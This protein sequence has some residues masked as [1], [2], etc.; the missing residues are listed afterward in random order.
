MKR[1]KTLMWV[2][3]GAVFVLA[4]TVFVVRAVRRD[5]AMHAAL[6]EQQE[7]N[8]ADT[9][10]TSDSV[11]R[12]LVAYFDHPWHRAND[13]MLAHYLLG[14]AH[15][16][17]GEAPQAI[18]DYQTAVECADTTDSDCDFRL[19]RNVYGQMA[20]VFHA[21]NLPEDELK[22]DSAFIRY[23]WM[24][25]DTLQ[26]INGYRAM[27]CPYFLLNRFDIV[28]TID[29]TAHKTFLALN[30]TIAAARA[31]LTSAFINAN[32]QDY[33]KVKDIIIIICRDADI[34]DD[35]NRLRH[36]YEMFYYTLGLYHEGI[37]QLDSAEYY[38]RQL[39]PAKKYEACYKG[40]LS[41]YSKR[42]IAD[43][44]AMHHMTA[45]VLQRFT[46][47]HPSTTTTVTYV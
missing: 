30:D 23:S 3:A 35:N 43:S 21:Q 40:L 32:N 11:A 27:E 25:G 41:V 4:V 47:R 46:K 9:V 45:Y 22:A 29:S 38:Y 14:R 24:I 12:V 18:E 26:A 34:Y 39:L 19:L 13:R 2:V 6:K 1:R 8:Q 42:C 5:R 17:M 20:E 44:I 15:A 16:D 31:L 10:F 36:G 28:Q 37:G 33:N 7:W